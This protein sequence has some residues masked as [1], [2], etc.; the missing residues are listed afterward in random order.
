[1][2]LSELTPVS[3][4]VWGA[5]GCLALWS[6][7][8]GARGWRLPHPGGPCLPTSLPPHLIGTQGELCLLVA[9]SPCAVLEPSSPF[10]RKPAHPESTCASV[11]PPEATP[12]SRHLHTSLCLSAPGVRRSGGVAVRPLGDLTHRRRRPAS[13]GRCLHSRAGHRC[14]SPPFRL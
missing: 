7:G 13:H 9:A 2:L 3:V 8:Q 14:G 1:M 12:G 5:Q 6:P 11:A 10:C 4:S